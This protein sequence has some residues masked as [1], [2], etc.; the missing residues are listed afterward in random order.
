MQSRSTRK[1]RCPKLRCLKMNPLRISWALPA[2]LLLAG[3]AQ[4]ERIPST[5]GDSAAER[6]LAR[7]IAFPKIEGKV[8]VMLNCV[9]QIQT[10]GKMKTTLCYVEN[11]FDTPFAAAVQKAAKKALM[12]PGV[13]DGKKRDMYLQ[14]RVEFI[15]DG[16]EQEILLYPNPAEPEN[17]KEYG[18]GHIAA[19]RS[20]GKEPWM[21]VCPQRAGYVIVARAHVNIEGVASSVSLHH[22]AGIVPTGPCQ[23]A[24]IDTVTGSDYAPATVDGVAV[25]S[26]FV[27][28]F[29]N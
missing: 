28:P 25:P 9:S 20:I 1:V 6:A 21:K 2:M 4:A 15:Q 23:Q 8:S 18:M 22:G 3:F 10:S 19:Q 27:E 14:F 13:I 26:T 17:L 29:G 11:Q 12:T 16:D 24:I 5:F 7:L